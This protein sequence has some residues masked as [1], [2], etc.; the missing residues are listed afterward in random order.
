MRLPA[1]RPVATSD[2]LSA[3]NLPRD[4][5]HRAKLDDASDAAWL[6]G[7]TPDAWRA[8]VHDACSTAPCLLRPSQAIFLRWLA[9][10]SVPLVMCCDG[11]GPREL[12]AA[13]ARAGRPIGLSDLAV[14][15][16]FSAAAAT[17]WADDA[18][19]PDAA[20]RRICGALLASSINAHLIQHWRVWLDCAQQE[21]SLRGL[22][23]DLSSISDW[24]VTWAPIVPRGRGRPPRVRHAPPERA[25]LL[26]I[27]VAIPTASRRRGR[28]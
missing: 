1:D 14:A 23:A 5:R 11:P 25:S 22:G 7:L 17:R 6:L 20:L 2:V 24:H 3:L 18:S 4:P 8:V 9:T 28:R 19:T 10:R 21:A 12:C 26:V 16:G 27:E 13:L 15:L